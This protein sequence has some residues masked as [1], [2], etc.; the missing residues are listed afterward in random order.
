MCTN[1]A[2]VA[3]TTVTPLPHTKR[4]TPLL[5]FSRSHRML[6]EKLV[7]QLEKLNEKLCENIEESVLNTHEI[8][9]IYDIAE[10]LTGS[11]I[12]SE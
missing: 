4:A 12:M 11:Y 10:D 2:N 6:I 1:L 8:W 3:K 5:F 9:M 7:Q